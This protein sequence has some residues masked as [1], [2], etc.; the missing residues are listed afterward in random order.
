MI[1]SARS[2]PLTSPAPLTDRPDYLPI[3]EAHPLRPRR[4]YDIAK[5]AME[6]IGAGFARRSA[7]RVAMFRPPLIVRPENAPG[8][9]AELNAG[10][11]DQGIAVDAPAY[12]G[13]PAFRAWVSSRDCAAAF[14]A[15]LEAD[16]ERPAHRGF[17][18]PA[19]PSST[20]STDAGGNGGTRLLDKKIK[21]EQCRR[22]KW[23]FAGTGR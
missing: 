15:A 1:R 14:A 11:E 6:V 9:V 23:P 18:C 17:L 4:A 19:Q 22:Q 16:F 21:T 3:D 12:G 20:K 10:G 8:I 2:S 7:M 5:Q 13:L